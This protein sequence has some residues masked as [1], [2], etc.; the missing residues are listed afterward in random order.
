M[1]VKKSFF[2][3]LFI[4]FLYGYT[5]S[6]LY[7]QEMIG[8]SSSNYAGINGS[9]LNPSSMS[10]SRN[11]IEVNI[12]SSHTFGKNNSLYIPRRDNRGVLFADGELPK[13]NNDNSL[14]LFSNKDAKN[15]FISQRI[16]LPSIM[17]NYKDHSFGFMAQARAYAS[18]INIPY[19]FPVIA[20]KG[21]NYMPIQN[22]NF[23]NHK[24]DINAQS[25]AEFSLLYSKKIYKNLFSQLSAGISLKYLKG[26][27]AAYMKF[28]NIKFDIPSDYNIEINNLNSEFGYASPVNLSTNR[29]ETSP[30]FIGEGVG[31]DLGFTYINGKKIHQNTYRMQ[32]CAVEFDEY[33]YKIGVSIIDVGQIRYDERTRVHLYDNVSARWNDAKINFNSLDS[34]FYTLDT[35]FYGAP[36][37]SLKSTA[38][39]M[40]L[41]T[42]ISIQA[43]YN[44]YKDFYASGVWVQGIKLFK[45][46][47]Y[48]GAL[49]AITP[50]YETPILEV[51]I[52]V[53]LYNYEYPDLGAYVRIGY[54]TIG[55]ES[56]SSLLGI[57]NLKGTDIYFSLKF[58]IQKGKCVNNSIENCHS[59]ERPL[60]RGKN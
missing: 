56:L 52:P 24:F 31:F 23:D 2:I 42:A 29:I 41:P 26:Y 21:L 4:L 59:F 20:Y 50:R 10:F 43:D 33:I 44:F 45:N 1:K 54:F 36:G 47:M 27:S 22:I 25:W 55:S 19:E 57:G 9:I 35:L 40:G 46:S 14:L 60:D 3:T 15:I 13:Y 11:Y 39:S 53:S 58:Y 16:I 18:G 49:L 28:D 48:R 5:N 34:L 12:I 38:F 51:G 8:L 32:P 37:R 30:L 6:S 7:G 17:Y